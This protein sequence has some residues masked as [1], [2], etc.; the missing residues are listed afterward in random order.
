M[1][2]TALTSDCLDLSFM[3]DRG[4]INQTKFILG[5]GLI[6]CNDKPFVHLPCHQSATIT[7]ITFFLKSARVQTLVMV[8]DESPITS[9]IDIYTVLT[10]KTTGDRQT[11]RQADT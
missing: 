5:M 8:L 4:S 3:V 1:L 2:E 9:T 10:G 11:D 6:D 7:I